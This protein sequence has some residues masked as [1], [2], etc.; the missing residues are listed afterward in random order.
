MNLDNLIDVTFLSGLSSGHGRSFELTRRPVVILTV[1][2]TFQLHENQT[3]IESSSV[4]RAG[5][6]GWA[7]EHHPA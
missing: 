2:S 4:I 1:Y 6:H 5:S 3:F 7:N